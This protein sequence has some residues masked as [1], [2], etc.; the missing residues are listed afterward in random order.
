[1]DP[2]LLQA[3]WAL[4]VLYLEGGGQKACSGVG[5]EWGGQIALGGEEG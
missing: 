1:M 5:G 3:C 2:G 4:T